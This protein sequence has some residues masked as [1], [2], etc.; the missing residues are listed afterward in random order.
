MTEGDISYPGR[1]II[2]IQGITRVLLPLV[3]RF[4]SHSAITAR[5]HYAVIRKCIPNARVIRITVANVGLPSS[6][7]AL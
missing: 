2:F 7:K 4:H 5:C 6:D 1:Y 3:R